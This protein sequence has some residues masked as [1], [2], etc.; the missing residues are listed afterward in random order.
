MQARGSARACVGGQR[1]EVGVLEVAAAVER[2]RALG[3]REIAVGRRVIGLACG[4]PQEPSDR[5][6]G[7][8]VPALAMKPSD[9][10][11]L[12]TPSGESIV[13]GSVTRRES[14]WPLGTSDWTRSDQV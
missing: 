3:R 2:Q 8:F 5:S 9:S 1:I 11:I 4:R 14:S 13:A 10:V 7:S 6:V 12:E